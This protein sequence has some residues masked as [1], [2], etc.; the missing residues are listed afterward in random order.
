MGFIADNFSDNICY[1]N[2]D[3]VM[4]VVEAAEN[5]GMASGLN[6]EELEIVLVAAWF[7]DTGYYLG[8]KNH[9]KASVKI[10]RKFLKTMLVDNDKIKLISSCIA[11]TK[12]PQKP[13]TLLEKVLCDADLYH[14]ATENFLNKSELLRQELHQKNH[15]L[16]MEKWHDLNC[17]FLK[18]HHFHTEYGKK[19]LRPIK[20]KNLSRLQPGKN[21]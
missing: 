6:D 7:H 21:I 9:E 5:I 3:H 14:L 16:T 19:C 4:D 2:I 1:H 10:A 12:I 15:N 8:E 18:S 11:S 13:K 20:F 17:H